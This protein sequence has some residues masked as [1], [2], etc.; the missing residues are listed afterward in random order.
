MVTIKKWMEYV[1]LEHVVQYLPLLNPDI[2]SYIWLCCS[3][4]SSAWG[5]HGLPSLR[6]KHQLWTKRRGDWLRPCT[7]EGRP[8]SPARISS[9]CTTEM[10]LIGTNIIDLIICTLPGISLSQLY[11]SRIWCSCKRQLGEFVYN[12]NPTLFFI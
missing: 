10:L 12:M 4:L 8:C 6:R 2:D 3:C 9:M 7:L 5:S 11:I 1:C